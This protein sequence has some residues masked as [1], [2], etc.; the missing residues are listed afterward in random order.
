MIQ[1]TVRR[2]QMSRSMVRLAVVLAFAA[3]LYGPG[4]V[5]GRKGDPLLLGQN[6]YAGEVTIDLE[7]DPGCGYAF[8]G[9]GSVGGLSRL[10]I[11]ATDGHPE[12]ILTGSQILTGHP[13]TSIAFLYVP[14]PSNIQ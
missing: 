5:D 8:P 1:S 12:A 10:G 2:V 3:V 14:G 6:L 11:G 9:G 4:V 7:A 13:P